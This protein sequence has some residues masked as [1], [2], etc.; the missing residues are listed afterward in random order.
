MVQWVHFPAKLNHQNSKISP[1]FLA[2][3]TSGSN[4][5]VLV[6]FETSNNLQTSKELTYLIKNSPYSV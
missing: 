5:R 6:Y 4:F 2:T 1:P 3:M